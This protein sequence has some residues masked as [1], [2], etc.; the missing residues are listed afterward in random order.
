MHKDREELIA[1][2]DARVHHEIRWLRRIPLLI[3]IL[4]AVVACYGYFMS[5]WTV[6]VVALFILTVGMSAQAVLWFGLWDI[7]KHQ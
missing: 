5:Y 7:N 4:A 2:L 1:M 6:M 3:G